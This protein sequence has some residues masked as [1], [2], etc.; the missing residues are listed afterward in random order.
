MEAL[1]LAVEI[2]ILIGTCVWNIAAIRGATTSLREAVTDMK[3]EQARQ[4]RNLR[5]TELRVARIEGRIGG[6]EPSDNG[7]HED[8]DDGNG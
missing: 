1:K 7:E 3:A 5:A 2:G 4:R 6:R 8:G